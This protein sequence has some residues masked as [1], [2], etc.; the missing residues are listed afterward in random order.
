[1]PRITTVTKARKSQG[2]CS[3]C[4][5]EIEAGESYKHASKRTSPYSSFRIVWCANCRPK[6]SQL[7]SGHTADLHGVMEG[8][9]ADLGASDLH[10]EGVRDALTSAAEGIKGIA[11]E[12]TEGAQ[13]IVEGFGHPT[14]QSEDMDSKAQE[15]TDFGDTLENVANDLQSLTNEYDELQTELSN[16]DDSEVERINEIGERLEAVH[17]E[18][19][20]T[21]Q[22]A[23]SE[24]SF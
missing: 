20:E 7:A 24:A 21:A 23:L 1:M 9:E 3:T 12:Y 19:T 10:P 6:A 2:R 15:L 22:E 14:S 5:T 8:A 4:G 17:E 16:I 13:N 18:A 11:E